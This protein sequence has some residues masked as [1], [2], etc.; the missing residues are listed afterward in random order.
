MSIIS[1]IIP[2]YAAEK[3][4]DRCVDSILV[5]TFTD[6]EIIL[7]DDGSKDNS[8]VI[9]D[10][11]AKIDRRVKVI[12]KENGGVSSARNAGL[13]NANGEYVTFIDSDDEIEA[14]YLKSLNDSIN[15]FNSDIA[16]CS[17]I[18]KIADVTTIETLSLNHI[19][20]INRTEET[21][22]GLYLFSKSALLY[23][24]WAKLFKK[25]IIDKNNIRFDMKMSLGED[26]K[27]VYEY[28]SFCNTISYV[29]KALYTY[30]D[31]EGSLVHSFRGDELLHGIEMCNCELNF[32]KSIGCDTTKLRARCA[33]FVLEGLALEVS[34]IL[35]D[36]TKNYFQK[37]KGISS[38]LKMPEV[39]EA[40]KYIGYMK[41]EAYFNK[42][43]PPSLSSNSII[44]NYL[45]TKKTFRK[46]VKFIIGK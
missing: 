31:N 45:K 19:D 17:F 6:F 42:I 28:L 27:F 46:K 34:K 30:Y 40:Q 23:G 2:V 16:V 15:E 39:V 12:H 13:E 36:R 32:Y 43:L 26:K 41:M 10:E 18:R 8:G 38:I 9:C 33:E 37:K 21:S 20:L 7:I 29:P 24:P 25:S 1:V 5:Q 44:S 4:L 14:E 35:N 3:Y 22:D 11:Y